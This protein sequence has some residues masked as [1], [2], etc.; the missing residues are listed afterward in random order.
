VSIAEFYAF[1]VVFVLS[2]YTTLF[3]RNTDNNDTA[4]SHSK[5]QQRVN[6]LA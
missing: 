1:F 5:K 3:I 2:L 6:I 4:M